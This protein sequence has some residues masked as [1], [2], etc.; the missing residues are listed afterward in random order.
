MS[1]LRFK[2]RSI[3][4]A[5]VSCLTFTCASGLG[6]AWADE[7][8]L[9]SEPGL[10][11]ETS[12]DLL[13]VASSF[14]T[15][16]DFDINLR[17][18]FD[19]QSRSA[20][21]RRETNIN[22]PGL[23][24]GGYLADNMDVATFRES[25]QRLIPEVN[26][27]LFR[28]LQLN[29]RLPVILSNNRSLS[30]RGG[31][32]SQP[33]TTAGLIGEQL[34]SPNFD[35]PTRS[36]I[37]Y[38]AVGLDMAVMNQFRNPSR[39]N[40]VFG[41]EGRF[42]VSE[43]M[44]ACTENPADGQENCA[45]DADINRNGKNELLGD[46]NDSFGSFADATEGDFTGGRG[47]GVSRGTTAIEARAYVSK[48]LKYIEPYT[49][50]EAFAE[51]PVKGSA[52]GP[53]DVEGALVNH[54]PLR[55]TV[56]AG[57]SVIPWEQPENYRRISLDFRVRGTYVSE[58]RDYSELF[59]ALGS[60]DAQ[61][62]RLPNYNSYTLNT[63][64]S[65]ADIANNPSV[66]SPDSERINFTGITDVQQHGDYE[67][68]GQFSWQASRFVKFDLGGAWRLIQEH[69]ITFD[70]ACNPDVTAVAARS[71]P[72]KIDDTSSS[73]AES[74][75]RAWISGGLPNPNHRKVINDPGQR[76]KVDASNGFRAWV[77]ASVLF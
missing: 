77:R 48:R 52:F 5:F 6:V 71:G 69:F 73:E 4:Q 50:V 8:M 72:C 32:A 53:F 27:G 60:S 35:S 74:G 21:V 30:E 45:Y 46:I 44:R 10:L 76:F 66:V 22:Q 14:D 36:G 17:L 19:H 65:P 47:P 34:F 20:P 24:T 59:D 25:T 54:P 33:I 39:P 37:E 12:V 7:P 18:S 70:Q 11:N 56:V 13:S 38:L 40:W 51:F 15:G 43:P 55:G 26:I 31:S 57:V 42:N 63:T 28:D 29:V 3:P 75:N 62:L 2:R 68:K 41:I 23:S 64:G 67:L 9:P 61:S 16:D 58:G 1:L 49:G